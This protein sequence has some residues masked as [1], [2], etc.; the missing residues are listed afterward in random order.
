MAQSLN[1]K[2]AFLASQGLVDPAVLVKPVT[3][4]KE[5]PEMRAKRQAAIAKLRTFLY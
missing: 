2:M 4:D 1:A 5:T 3:H